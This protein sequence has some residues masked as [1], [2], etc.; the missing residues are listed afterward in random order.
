MQQENK[1]A[2][3]AI[4]HNPLPDVPPILLPATIGKRIGDIVPHERT[5]W[6]CVAN[7]IPLR[8]EYWMQRQ[9]VAGDHISLHPVVLGGGGSRSLLATIAAVVLSVFAPYLAAGMLGSTVA[10][11][12]VTGALLS[13]GIVLVGTALINAIIPAQSANAGAGAQASNTYNVSLSGN[14]A[15]LGQPIPVGYGRLRTFPDYAAQPY[16]EYDT[17]TNPDGDQFFYGLF[18]IGHGDY[19]I[20]AVMISDTAID[21]FSNV[22][23]AILTP[24][25]HPTLVNPAVVSSLE[26]GGQELTQTPVGPFVACGPTRRLSHIGIDIVFPRG[27]AKINMSD[28][29]AGSASVEIKID[30]AEVND[31][32]QQ[33]SPWVNIGTE[34]ITASSLT[35]Q[36]RSFK[37]AVPATKRYVARVYRTSDPST[38][39]DLYDE[40]TWAGLRGYLVEDAP[41]APTVTHLEIRIKANEQLT[42][43]SQRKIGV[44][45]RRKIRTWSPGAGFSEPVAT[46]NPMWAL[47]DKWTNSV[48]GDRLDTSRID[49]NSVYEIAQTCDA[50]KDR[51]DFIFD[52]RTTSF[53]ADQLIGRVCRSV[54]IR[55]NGARSIVR[56]DLQDLPIT[57]FTSRN[58]LRDSTSVQYMQVTEETADGVIVEYFDRNAFDWFDVECPAPG[59]TYTHPAH[60]GYNPDLPPMENPVRVQFPGITGPWHAER[61]GLYQAAA[62]TL[63]RK[64]CTWQT[65]LNAV[66]AWFGAPVIFA[67]TLHNALQS[68]DCAFYYPDSNTLS[69][70]EP[71]QLPPTAKLVLM[72]PDG[73]VTLPINITAGPDVYSVILEELPDFEINTK[74]S[75]TERTKYVILDS[76]AYSNLCKVLAIRPQ[77]V[78][79]DGAPTYEIMAV[80][81]DPE[82]HKVDLHLIPGENDDPDAPEEWGDDWE[83][84][85]PG[86]S[87]V[88][89]LDQII[90]SIP[91]GGFPDWPGR[92]EIEF[93]SDGRVIHHYYT[94]FGPVSDEQG[95]G[96]WYVNNP[97]EGIGAGYEIQ[98]S[99]PVWAPTPYTW[100]EGIPYTNTGIQFVS[101]W[102]PLTEGQRI[103][104]A[105]AEFSGDP[106]EG[107]V[108]IRSAASKVVQGSAR[109][110]Q[111]WKIWTEAP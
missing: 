72:R 4:H 3:V 56:D 5:G 30:I 45:W 69:M 94:N 93:T 21:S 83:A 37:Y 89:L 47:L 19:E 68:G 73:S 8:R 43:A 78:T 12:G 99:T 27:L 46:R 54:P 90:W 52:T 36:R 70:S 95:N 85:D 9:I 84:G 14:Q 110:R 111:D 50:R 18:A 24:G 42:G 29:S 98:F 33:R 76:T 74:N 15:K 51:F 48:Y 102:L 106:F 108:T 53:E 81:D 23:Y 77:G 88:R 6:V 103:K 16:I 44:L 64:Y 79:G 104:F 67:P 66:L 80:V 34:T 101:P 28:G 49:M 39:S 31:A 82:V 86:A 41:L 92:P 26:V 40:A 62:N 105:A 107:R 22:E 58:I 65:E 1:P 17:A 35:A 71:L 57:A 60:P 100:L 7:G 11:M 59:R 38:A 10:T 61:E 13:A 109:L 25:Q 75:R 32:F 96:Q 87:L 55:R 91:S 97:E 2:V 20:V 63:R